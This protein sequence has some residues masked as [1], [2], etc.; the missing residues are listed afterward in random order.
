MVDDA[1]G[2]GVLGKNGKGTP[3]HFGLADQVDLVMGTF[4]KSFASLGGFIA[5]DERVISYIK[6]HSRALIF[7][8][9][10]PPSAIA[11]VQAALEVIETEP[12]IRQRLWRNTDFLREAVTDLGFNI[13]DTRTPIIPLI[14]GDDLRT[15]FFWHRLFQEGVFSNCVIAPGV[16]PGTQ[17]I[18]TTLMAT[19]T[20][21]DLAKVVEICGRVGKELGIIN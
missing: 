19:H 21:E 12:E 5:G 2:L 6:H 4:S 13:G 15:A 3:E 1:H 9:A 8:A 10:M 11:A 18:R 17:R 16:P 7:S 14:V 20:L